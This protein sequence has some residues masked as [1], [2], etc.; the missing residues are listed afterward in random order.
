MVLINRS[1]PSET[2]GS[3]ISGAKRLE[4]L[5][6]AYTND[7]TFGNL[8][9]LRYEFRRLRTLLDL[10]AVPEA[11][12]VKVGDE[13]L[14][15][16]ADI[17][18]RL[19]APDLTKIPGVVAGEKGLPASWEIPGTDIQI[20]RVTSGPNTGAYL[21]TT[22]SI[23]ALADDYIRMQHLP[24][25]HPRHYPLFHLEYINATGPF[26]PDWLGKHIPDSLKADYL[27]TP[28]WKFIAIACVVVLMLAL[29]YG[30]VRVV[31]T[32]S[33]HASN[34]KKLAWHFTLPT[35]FLS[36][37]YLSVQL[38]IAHINP[39]GLLAMGEG[40]LATAIWYGLAAWAAW[41][42]CLLLADL[43]ISKPGIAGNTLD[44]HLLRLTARIAAICLA[45]GFLIYGANEIGIP[46]YGLVTGIGVGGIALALAAQSTIENLFGGIALFADRP[47]R[48][49]DTISFNNALGTVE[50]VGTRSTR[51]RALDG[52]FVTMPNGD[53][54]KMKIENLT[55]RNKCLVAQ[56]FSVQL[57][58]SV[59]QLRQLLEGIRRLAAAEETIEKSDGWPRVRCVGIAVGH[60]DVDLRAYVLTKDYT[61]FLEIQEALLLQIL[62]LIEE[63]DIP[64]ARP[65]LATM[66]ESTS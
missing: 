64:L 18:I 57:D 30:W 7:K 56:R 3:L 46:A 36:I 66:T 38:L 42:G 6:R 27:N 2:Y 24:V 16:L 47:F 28:I 22:N 19:P 44:S 63:L 41:I 9:E 8:R 1:S 39:A 52:T 25:L 49:G 54:A 4:S 60:I 35:M 29:A 13:A 10:S 37:Y 11:S 51:I 15:Y 58:T 23:D 43:V 26:I 17:L 31:Q 14:T 62:E 48:I 59:D 32:Q 34:V 40:L 5:Y 55:R 45:G 61:T 53:L 33:R 20:A 12:R 21:V 65:V 50:T